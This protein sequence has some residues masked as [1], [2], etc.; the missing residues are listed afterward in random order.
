MAQELKKLGAKVELFENSILVHSAPLHT[1]TETL[2][3]HNDHRIV[4]SLCT[5]LTQLGG[6]IEGAEAV[7]KSFPDFFDKLKDVDIDVT[8]K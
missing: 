7:S 3:S 4:M 1:P 5:L 8:T 6:S 2:C